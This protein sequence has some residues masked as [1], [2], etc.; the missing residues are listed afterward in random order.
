MGLEDRYTT[1]AEALKAG[2]YRTW[3]IGKWH[4][5]FPGKAVGP[6]AHG[7]D[8]AQDRPKGSKGHYLSEAAMK[9]L[10]METNSHPR[11]RTRRSGR[12]L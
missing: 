6:T 4:L 2:G 8:F 12:I 5:D 11:R 9:E 3:Q 1:V 7:F 10:N